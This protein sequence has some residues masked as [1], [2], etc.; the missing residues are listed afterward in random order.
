MGCGVLNPDDEDQILGLTPDASLGR[1]RGCAGS[2]QGDGGNQDGEEARGKI[3]EP[4]PSDE[5]WHG[6]S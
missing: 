4:P 6:H 2:D 3:A 5:F 1:G